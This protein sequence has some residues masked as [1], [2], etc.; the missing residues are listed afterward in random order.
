[1]KFFGSYYQPPEYSHLAHDRIINLIL[2]SN[3]ILKKSIFKIHE[4]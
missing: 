4:K 3:L 2:Q 1:M